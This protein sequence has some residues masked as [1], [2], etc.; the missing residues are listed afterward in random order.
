[1]THYEVLEIS[2]NASAIDIRRAYRR[3]VLLTHPDRTPDPAAHAR[4]LTINEAYE[5]LSDP[6]RRASYDFS[7]RNAMPAAAP[8]SPGQARD[9]ARPRPPIAAP[10]ARPRPANQLLAAEQARFLR[11][12]RPVMLAALALCASLG[13]DRLFAREQPET[14]LQMHIVDAW[15][16]VHQTTG[17]HFTL[18]EEIPVHAR[19]RVTRTPLW[20]TALRLRV[21]QTG[22]VQYFR[23][24]YQGAS[25]VFWLGLGLTALLSLRTRIS[26][27]SRLMATLSSVVFM[28]LTLITLFAT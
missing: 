15:H 21:E 28:I 4:Y 12:A 24:L 26:D 25:N 14:V 17:G 27:E 8:V 16:V 10:G 5:I 20:R 22:E 3:L 23:S 18:D 6:G 13:L 11:L 2:E 7:R 9:R 19:L 1:M